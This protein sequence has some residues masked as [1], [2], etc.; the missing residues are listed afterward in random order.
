MYAVLKND[1]CTVKYVEV[2]GNHLIL[3][4]HNQTSPIEVIPM[5]E[6]KTAA[7]YL[8]GRVCH[9]GVEA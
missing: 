3:R 5:E 4:P 6:G 8:V 1:T 7:D 9:V 2:A